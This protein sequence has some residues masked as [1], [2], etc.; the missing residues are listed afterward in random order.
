[1]DLPKGAIFELHSIVSGTPQLHYDAWKET[2]QDVL[3][4][5]REGEP[6]RGFDYDDDY[7]PYVDGRPRYVAVRAF[8]DSCDIQLP[9]GHPADPPDRRTVCGIANRKN[10][11]F[12]ELLSRQ[13]V[14]P[15]EDAVE[16]IGELR[17]AG[18]RTGLVSSS[19][20][21][22]AVLEA[23]GLLEQF[24]TIV[25]GNDVVELSLPLR[26]EPDAFVMAVENLELL[27]S[28]CMLAE[29]APEGCRAGTRGNFG[30]VVGIAR[31]EDPQTLTEYGADITVGGLRELTG[32]KIRHW[33]ESGKEQ[34]AWKL[35][36][37]QFHPDEEMLREALTTVGNGYIGSRGAYCSA[38]SYDDIHYPGTYVAGLW[39]KLGTEVHGHTVYNDDFVNIPNWLLIELKIADGG[40]CRLLS[41]TIEEYEH[42]LDMKRAVLSRRL[43]IKDTKGHRTLIET[44]RFLSMAEPHL[45][46][47][48]Y[49]I[50]PLN[51]SERVTLRSSIDGTVINYGVP[52]YR[53]LSSQHLEVV[54]TAEHDGRIEL[55]AR[56]TQSRVAILM[57]ARH[58]VTE[59]G[60]ELSAA[61]DTELGEGHIARLMHFTAEEG[62]TYTVRKFVS[63][64]TSRDRDTE[65][66]LA[67]MRRLVDYWGSGNAR[68]DE[69]LA[70]HVQRWAE[71]WERADLRIEP[72]RFSQRVVR[73]HTYH[74]LVSHSP[75][76][77]AQ[78]V[79]FTARGLHGEA[80]RGHVFWDEL[81]VEP[82]Y[83]LR[84][85]EVTRGHLMYRYR[86]LDAARELA[87]QLGYQGAMYP[88]QS[89]DDGGEESQEL[90]YNPRSGG[91][92]PDLS[93]N[94]RHVSLAIAYDVWSYYYATGDQTFME[95][96][97]MEM[98]VEICRFWVSKAYYDK[99]DQRYHIDGVMGPDEF[100]E[101]YPDAEDTAGFLD[102]AYTNIMTAWI[103]HKTIETWEHQRQPVRDTVA[104]RIGLDEQGEID[105]WR[106]VI[107]GLAVEIGDDEVMSQFTGYRTLEELDWDAYKRRYD[108]IRRMDRILKAEGD[109]PDRYQ[110]AKQADALMVFYLLSPGQV[111]NILEMMGYEIADAKRFATRNYEYYLARTSQ[112]STLSYIVHSA[113][114]RYVEG[115]RNDTWR[116]FIAGLESDI[117]DTQGGTT[118][119]AIHCGVMAG[120]LG[121]IIENF[122]GINL[123]RDHIE[124]NPDLPRSWN[125]LAFSLVHR[126]NLFLFEI[127][128]GTMRIT[129]RALDADRAE[130]MYLRVGEET[131]SLDAQPLEVPYEQ[132]SA[133]MPS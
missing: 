62:R 27:P 59:D 26:P 40:Y 57:G 96:Y 32:D 24:D 65:D 31:D 18:V 9:H 79:G 7:R 10:E 3:A 11:L 35:T 114:S 38:V 72:D 45:G 116:W 16:R 2:F 21:C 15:D 113:I 104:E 99:T 111:T 17:A 60:H 132:K 58:T 20:N 78:D 30:L 94:Q 108:N 103:L 93:R 41:C 129:R 34:D 117:L 61:V 90:H 53:D 75:N 63:I 128:P 19:R 122:A 71:L 118:R 86:R 12:R 39:N 22:R 37:R 98:L 46:V 66:P 5:F 112:G 67:D 88:W 106:Q 127:V 84:F 85:P 101:K 25:D 82:F 115:H 76:S 70:E 97:G 1:M 92:D 73:L 52:R 55:H 74:L 48:E 124:V 81:F 107:S 120:T 126:G 105:H 4:E 23:A 47:L 102:N 80:Y 8:L 83:N 131:Y 50:T 42:T 43:R 125:S 123:F 95:N 77:A 49:R 119:E 28:E 69:A 64:H 68:F 29:A 91:W 130:A 121:I 110:V 56:T 14:R 36:Y 54:T 100:H 51:Y 44:R 133:R 6:P 89:A 87:R 13:G 33:F 109:S